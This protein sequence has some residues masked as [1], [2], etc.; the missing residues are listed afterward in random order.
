MEIRIFGVMLYRIHLTMTGK[1]TDNF[2]LMWLKWVVDIHCIYYYV[3]LFLDYYYNIYI[4]LLD[5]WFICIFCGSLFVLSFIF[6][7][8]LCCL[9]FFDI[10][11][12]ITPFVSTSSSCSVDTYV[13]GILIPGDIFHPIA[14]YSALTLLVRYVY[15]WN[16]QCLD[17]A[18]D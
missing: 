7:W 8:P 2:S 15:V 10:R 3:F 1:R 9:Y 4:S 16:V 5:L 12:L 18:I 13:G 11:I 17:Y 6:F 14:A